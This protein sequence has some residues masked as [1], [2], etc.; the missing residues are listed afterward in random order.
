MDVTE[1]EMEG[2][3]WINLDEDRGRLWAVVN[4]VMNFRFP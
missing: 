3:V 1:I 4:A 2:V